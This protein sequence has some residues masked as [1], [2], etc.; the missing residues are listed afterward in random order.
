MFKR[1]L[2]LDRDGV[3]NVRLPGAYVQEPEQ[4][5]FVEGSIDA[6]IKARHHF[7]RI[8]VVTNQQ[9]IG[10]ELMTE[11]DL[12]KVHQKMLD[13]IK[14]K[15]GQ[16]DAVFHCPNLAAENAI[17]RK[18]NPGMALQAKATFPEIEFK[19]SVMVGDSVSD[20]LFGKRLGMKTVL[21]KSNPDQVA[22]ASLLTVDS[23]Y[24]S[25][26]AWTN[27]LDKI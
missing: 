18:P 13:Q 15:G 11:E 3:I 6:I 25:L 12:S 26:L 9:G 16:I 10:K 2:F 22:K 14:E 19:K 21:I 5:E 24:D 27:T 4:F 7:D 20:M 8:V 17:C 23:Q 1:T